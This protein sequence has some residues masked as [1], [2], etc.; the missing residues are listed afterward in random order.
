MHVGLSVY[1]NQTIQ[2]GNPAPIYYLLKSYR[3]GS[4]GNRVEIFTGR[5]QLVLLVRV[6]GN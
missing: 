1:V 3:V 2:L 6:L 4:D 5:K